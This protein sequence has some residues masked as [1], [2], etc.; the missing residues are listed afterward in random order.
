MISVNNLTKTYGKD[1]AVKDLSFQV[2]EGQTLALVGTSGCGKTT[3][4]K[5]INRLVEPT[6]GEIILNGSNIMEEPV[7]DIRRR[8]GYV[9][10]SIG[11]FPHYTVEENVGVAPKLLGWP[12]EKTYQRTLSLLERLKL[13]PEKF[14]KKYPHE[15]S[16]GQR[17]RVGIARALAADPP[18]ILMDEPF[19][20]LDPITRM[21]IQQDFKN[22][23]ELSG[24]TTVLVTH[25]IEEA[26]KLADL[27]CVL[28]QGQLQQF[29]TPKDLLFKPANDFIRRFL[30]GQSL[31]LMMAVFSLADLADSLPEGKGG[32][33]FQAADS[34]E[35]TL[36]QLTR[37]DREVNQGYFQYKGFNRSFNWSQLMEAFHQ[38]INR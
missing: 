29:D 33:T 28:H 10:Q 8:M 31:S 1:V 3:T 16:G 13:P 6:S 27:V 22:L 9:I 32:S 21:D 30:S 2:A 11:L 15:L 5:M 19:G 14:L 26:F 12:A 18:I 7:V 37:V 17:Q 23:E 36:E 34:L 24:K 20:A 38:T 4:L 25:D 35:K